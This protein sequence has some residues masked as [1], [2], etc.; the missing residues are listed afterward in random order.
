EVTAAHEINETAEQEF[1]VPP[2]P[3]IKE[4][5]DLEIES[6]N[7]EHGINKVLTYLWNKKKRAVLKRAFHIWQI[8]PPKLAPLSESTHECTSC[9]TTYQGNYCPRCGQ[10]STVGRFSFKKALQHFLDV[11]GMG[12]RSMFRSLR[13]LMLRPGYMIRDYLSGMQSAYFPPFK[14]FFI[15]LTF[16]LIIEKGI[17]LDIDATA[18]QPAGNQTEMVKQE[19]KKVKEEINRNANKKDK[20]TETKMYYIVNKFAN[21]MIALWDKNPAIF[22]LVTI[23]LLFWPMYFFLHQSPKIPELRF[24]EFIVA[25]VYTSNSF[26]IYMILG[27]LLNYQPLQA[28]AV[29]IIFVALR[30][31]SGYKKRRIL[32]YLIISLVISVIAVLL[33]AGGG[34]GLASLFVSE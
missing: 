27:D 24:S 2:I 19:R 8:T 4:P 28:I 6:R 21:L 5:C 11:W 3:E 23:L 29:F 7:Q 31:L 22:S 9:G 16:F 15:L 33:V 30:Q 20:I 26:T 34:I 10:S 14:M 32:I 13:D 25:M 18:I 17:E 1:E 12:N